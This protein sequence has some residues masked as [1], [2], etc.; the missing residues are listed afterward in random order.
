ML[1][2]S[3]VPVRQGIVAGLEFGTGS[4]QHSLTSVHRSPMSLT[5]ASIA[6]PPVARD[7]EKGLNQEP[8]IVARR[9]GRQ[10]GRTK[11]I[12]GPGGEG[13]G[14]SERERCKGGKEESKGGKRVG[15]TQLSF[16]LTWSVSK[17]KALVHYADL[18]GL[19]AADAK[20]RTR[21]G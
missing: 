5:H 4:L 11:R 14:G 8:E 6:A 19:A 17:L 16:Y 20:L 7:Y 3:F 13:E 18:V 15:D 9:E 12:E 2:Q 10:I 21:P 1:V